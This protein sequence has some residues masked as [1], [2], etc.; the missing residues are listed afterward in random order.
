VVLPRT[1]PR[2]EIVAGGRRLYVKEGI[3]ITSVAS[4]TT[5]GRHIILPSRR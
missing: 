2:V 3:A 1:A 5:G 4:D